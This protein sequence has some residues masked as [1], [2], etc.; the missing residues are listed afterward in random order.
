MQARIIRPPGPARHRRMR[1]LVPYLFLLPALLINVCIVSGPVLGTLAISLT[2]WDG[3]HGARFVGLDNYGALLQ[4]T[5]FTYA[6]RNNFKWMLVF[7]TVPIALGLFTAVTLR[8][9][10]RGQ[11]FFRTCLFLPYIVPTVVTAEIWS[12]IY[13]PF[14][15]VDS[16]LGAHGLPTPS[17]LGDPSLSLFSIA[18]VDEWRFW[19]FVMVIL[20]SALHQADRSLEEAARIDGAGSLSVF[21]QIIVPQLRPTLVLIVFLSMIWSFTAFDYVYVMTRGGP[22]YSTELIATYMYKE[23]FQSDMPGYA[24]AIALTMLLFAGMVVGGLALL[25]RRGWD[26]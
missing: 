4:D 7:C 5:H 8:G 1:S 16:V 2:N 6:L 22:G 9:M 11:M 23:A 24:S 13:N 25:R 17:W 15:G 26:V 12:L 10:R 14:T 18:L 19:G 21:W 20:L 3:L